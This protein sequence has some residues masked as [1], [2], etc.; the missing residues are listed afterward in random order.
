[1]EYL[2]EHLPDLDEASNFG[3]ALAKMAERFDLRSGRSDISENF[4]AYLNSLPLDDH[5]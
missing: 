1:V 3:Y 2:D 4:D 5:S